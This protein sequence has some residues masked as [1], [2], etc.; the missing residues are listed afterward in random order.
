MI[1]YRGRFS[2]GSIQTYFV[3]I[4]I[5][6]NNDH[7]VISQLHFISLIVSSKQHHQ[8]FPSMAYTSTNNLLSEPS[9]C[10]YH[11][12]VNLR[13]DT[14]YLFYFHLCKVH[15]WLKA[16]IELYALPAQRSGGFNAHLYVFIQ[17]TFAITY[18]ICNL[19]PM[20]I[21][22]KLNLLW[23]SGVDRKLYLTD[24]PYV[25]VCTCPRIDVDLTQHFQPP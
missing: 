25:I 7:H 10:R 23:I 9:G 22:P 12:W 6:C 14:Y 18:N 17:F 21:S 24:P 2:L 8:L 13:S 16:V 15:S 3:H 11:M 19:L 5:P 1:S 4:S 20:E